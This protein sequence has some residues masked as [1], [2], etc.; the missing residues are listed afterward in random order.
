M[1]S[2]VVPRDLPTISAFVGSVFAKHEPMCRVMNVT[3]EEIR[4]SFGWIIGACCDSGFS[5]IVRNGEDIYSVSLALPYST[6][7]SLPDPTVTYDTIVPIAGILSAMD[8][9]RDFG[10]FGDLGNIGERSL[11]SSDVLYHFMCGTNPY[12]TNRGY[13]SS[14][15]RAT[16]DYAKQKGTRVVVADATNFVSQYILEN[17]FGYAPIHEELYANHAHFRSISCTKGVKRL[18]KHL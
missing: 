18:V 9:H 12:F 7:E 6:Y 4:R 3:P 5:S 17:R 11:V 16:L 2:R 1:L 10:D 14:T 13:G 15:I 8:E